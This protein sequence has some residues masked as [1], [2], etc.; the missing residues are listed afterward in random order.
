MDWGVVRA[1]RLGGGTMT[2]RRALVLLTLAVLAP[3]LAVVAAIHWHQFDIRRAQ[4][5]QANLE[6][7]RAMA[8]RV[9]QYVQDMLC[10]LSILGGLISGPE[11]PTGAQITHLLTGAAG[12]RPSVLLTALVD[13]EGRI[14]YSSDPRAVGISIAGREYF[15]QVRSG[16]DWAVSDMLISL[17]DQKPTFVVARAVHG[18]QGDFLGLVF[19]SVNPEVL[20]DLEI[21]P[22]RCGQGAVVVFDRQGTLVFRRP[23]V[24]LTWEKRRAWT[25]LDPMLRE[26]L[27]GGR[28]RVGEFVSPV[29]GQLR[30]AARTPVGDIGWV[31]GA[32]RPVAETMAPVYQ[33]LF[34]S[35]GLVV[36]VAAG[37]LIGAWLVGGR[38]T[39][40]V[41]RLQ[42]HA[43]ALGR[44]EEAKPMGAAGIRELDEVAAAFSRMRE[45]V[46]G[47][48]AALRESEERL[49]LAAEAGRVGAWDLD[50]PTKRLHWSAVYLKLAGL[51][52]E[53]WGGRRDSFLDVLHPDD[54]ERI[55][56]MVEQAIA[57]RRPTLVMEF[58]IVRPDGQVRWMRGEGRTFYD[59]DGR[60]LRDIG[61]AVDITERKR[62]EDELRK[63]KDEL[64]DRIGERTAELAQTVEELRRS[65]ADLEHFAYAASHD[66]QEPLR[67]VASFVQLLALRYG[68]RLDENGRQYIDQ[69]VEG[70]KRMSTLIKG[71]LDYSRVST[72]ART[73]TPTDVGAVLEEVLSDLHLSIKEAGAQVAAD[74]LPTVP[75]DRI[76]LAQVFRN[77]ISNAVKFRHPDRP[78][79]VRISAHRQ[80]GAWEFRVCDNGI[81]IESVYYERIFEIFQ[82]LHTR[83]YYEGTG[84][85]LALVK[86]IIDRHGG[87][88]W[89]ESQFGEGSTFFFTIPVE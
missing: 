66:L 28:E 20:S 41:E 86:R 83:R 45:Q 17:V 88:I 27:A 63:A 47:R 74:P 80:D 73:I 2:L 67:Q 5:E 32:S 52:P 42:S 87:R 12:E 36:L 6:L 59:A 15:Q 62:A 34:R 29:D 48:E 8:V 44:G 82:R 22:K 21:G 78:P 85:G 43:V 33:G 60:P 68:D 64:E 50:F 49:T 53:E 18:G 11:P 14:V 79:T 76:Q 30:M 84:I 81:G 72:Q 89:V 19:T 65:N 3:M 70:A 39:G 13:G 69:A 16:K 37:S 9:E 57:E 26:T 77:L 58:R 35:L 71:L 24:P 51:R 23:S 61:V 75:A 25:R 1:L 31:A 56:G 7:A 55:M 40:Q 54:R 10:D 4:E 46:A 38:I